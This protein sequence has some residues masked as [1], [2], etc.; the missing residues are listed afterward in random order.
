MIELGPVDFMFRLPVLL[1]SDLFVNDPEGEGEFLSPRCCEAKKFLP[2]GGFGAA[3]PL[4]PANG[5]LLGLRLG[6]SGH[7]NLPPSRSA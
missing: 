2:V 7:C 1:F 5:I 4:V 3:Y 6:V